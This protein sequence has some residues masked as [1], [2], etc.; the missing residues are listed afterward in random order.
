MCKAKHHTMST[1]NLVLDNSVNSCCVQ[2]RDKIWKLTSSKSF[3]YFM[4]L[5]Y[6]VNQPVFTC[7]EATV[8]T[9]G[10]CEIYSKLSIKTP[11]RRQ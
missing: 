11:K 5:C 3:F 8:E 1:E 7:S 2:A 10:H 9:P 6:F 4:V